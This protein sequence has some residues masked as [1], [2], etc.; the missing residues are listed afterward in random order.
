MAPKPSESVADTAPLWGPADGR[1]DIDVPDRYWACY[2]IL[3]LLGIG[4]L[5]PWNALITPT[6]YFQL[7]LTGSPFISS[8]ESILS[9][10]FTFFSFTWVV[11]LQWLQHVIPIRVCILGG[12]VTLLLALGTLTVLAIEP[13]FAADDELL[14]MLASGATG[15]FVALISC[16]A[17][18][19]I[20]QAF[21]TVMTYSYAAV[22]QRPQYL[23]AISG[24][25]GVAGLS[26]TL[27][28]ALL[29]LP[30]IVHECASDG[31]EARA[32][33]TTLRLSEGGPSVSHAR[34]LIAAASVYFSASC[35]VILACIGAFL[36]LEQLPFT[37]ARQRMA[38]HATYVHA[39]TQSER[40]NTDSSSSTERPLLHHVFASDHPSPPGE[41]RTTSGAGPNGAV[42]GA[43]GGA[44]ARIM[45][46]GGST[47]GTGIGDSHSEGIRRRVAMSDEPEMASLDT[48]VAI[49]ALVAGDADARL[50][51][52]RGTCS[53][54]ARLWKWCASISL[55]YIVTIAIFPALTVTIAPS[56]G[57]C[58]S[59]Q[60]FVPL[61]FV[62]FNLGDTIGRNL[63][64]LL[65]RP[66]TILTAVVSRVI[67]APLFMLCY[68]GS[69]DA[70]G[71][72]QLPIFE[73]MD[74][75][76][77]VIM[78]VSLTSNGLITS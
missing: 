38:E 4:S 34:D 30:G 69:G 40:V 37:R 63:P 56:G 59:K 71:P 48:R 44:R 3:Y 26:V 51:G 52:V 35:V 13:L 8:F 27:A 41:H 11:L 57:S 33:I 47:G 55:V 9:V 65:S 43:S 18:C 24:G 58:A 19:G 53:L 45:P 67:F 72:L 42:M 16:A 64:C 28:N 60:L 2:F 21:L 49:D 25:Q 10:S 74:V 70:A 22:Y 66:S 29:K 23:Q 73:G 54:V 46:T 75:M 50:G 62:I 20:G 76:P 68:T 14:D 78:S 15:Q 31:D 12:L 77:F 36:V 1:P 17:I 39:T 5:L 61:G 6:E 7:R 32:P